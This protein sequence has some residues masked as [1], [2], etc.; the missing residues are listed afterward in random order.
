MMLC[1][2]NLIYL[3]YLYFSLSI[4]CGQ[5]YQFTAFVTLREIIT[6]FG[7][8]GY[9]PVFA[10]CVLLIR[11]FSSAQRTSQRRHGWSFSDLTDL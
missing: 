6:L 8:C 5:T 3:F 1:T 2:S 10:P 7:C 9:D 11:K 4:L